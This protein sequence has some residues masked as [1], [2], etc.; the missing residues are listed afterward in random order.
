MAMANAHL[1]AALPNPRVLELC[2]VQGPLQWAILAA[3]PQIAD[4]WLVFPDRPGLGVTLAD[5]LAELFPFIEGP[6]GIEVSR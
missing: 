1:I 4:G 5:G 3:P 2:M 6:Y